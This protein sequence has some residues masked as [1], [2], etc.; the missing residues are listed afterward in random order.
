MINEEPR[1][2]VKFSL[3]DN[4]YV[5]IGIKRVSAMNNSQLNKSGSHKNVLRILLINNLIQ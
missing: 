5:L 2:P 4:I 1:D 3:P